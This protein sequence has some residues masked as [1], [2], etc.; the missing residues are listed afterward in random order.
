MTVAEVEAK[1]RSAVAR[2]K[3]YGWHIIKNAYWDGKIGICPLGA[4]IIDE[5]AD[6][7]QKA[8]VPVRAAKRLGITECDAI[9]VMVGVDWNGEGRV[10][11][12]NRD[13][14]VRY[15]TE[16]FL[17]LGQRLRDLVDQ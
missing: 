5:I 2:A 17:A 10:G 3:A 14:S 9:D 1:I 6:A 11:I 13:G 7:S 12:E 15:C 8:E 4:C 16:D